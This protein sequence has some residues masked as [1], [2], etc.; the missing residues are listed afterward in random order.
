M[1]GLP[2]TAMAFSISPACSLVE[3]AGDRA[4]RLRFSPLGI[5]V[6]DVVKFLGPAPGRRILKLA[7]RRQGNAGSNEGVAVPESESNTASVPHSVTTVLIP[8]SDIRDRVS[9]LARRIVADYRGKPLTVVGVLTG[10]LVLLA[11]L[12]RQIDIPL[13]VALLQ[14]SSYKGATTVSGK[15]VINEAFHPDVVDR[16]VLLLDDILDSGQT[17]STLVEHLKKLG[18]RSVRTLVLMRKQGRQVVAF[19]PDYCGFEIP[20]EFVVGYGL[21]YDDDYRQLPYIGILCEGKSTASG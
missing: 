8:E 18:A 5:R 7:Q 3:R 1:V 20:N 13:R 2:N 17:I 16:D 15:L 9:E 21:D 12:I 6:P 14:A 11:D 19:E 4:C 10:S